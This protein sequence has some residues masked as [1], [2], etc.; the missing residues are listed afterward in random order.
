M[1]KFLLLLST[2]IVL[3][4]F[5]S[6][7]TIKQTSSVP[8]PT[9][10]TNLTPTQAATPTPEPTEE[11]TEVSSEEPVAT[12]TPEP[13]DE[14]YT[15]PEEIPIQEPTVA[16][17][18][19]PTQELSTPETKPTQKPEPIPK[20]TQKPSPTPK[21][22]NK[23]EPTPKPKVDLSPTPINEN[24]NSKYSKEA[25]NIINNIIT[26]DM[27]DVEKIKAVHD[28]I[29]VNTEY[30][31]DGLKKD[32]LPSSAYTEEGVLIKGKAVCQG[33]AE[34]F[35]LFME[36][37]KIESK[38][39]VGTDLISNI[40]HAWNMV[41][42]KDNWYHIDITWDDPVPDQ[43]EK[44]QYKYFLIRDIDIAKDHHWV[45]SDYPKCNSSDYLYYIYKDY[46]V[47]SIDNIEGKFMEQYD[48]GLR[49][50]TLLYPEEG[51]P[52]F[53]F[54][55]KYDYL[56]KKVDGGLKVD[57]SYYPPWQLGDYYV[58]IVMME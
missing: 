53:A 19:T 18:P 47:D 30:D 50:I 9:Q 10:M 52:D 24:V 1:R 56:W 57:Y 16:P 32:N 39:V 20:P 22:T 6:C 51:M 15:E 29:V 33:Y 13:T 31:I 2:Y 38:M 25:I 12:P 58:L 35:Q 3:A 41:R 40:G 11:P 54:M 21:P 4:S 43:G 36:L 28:Y 48:K 45:R 44:I 27:S 55:N 23:P 8:E 7:S 46:I 37:L 5:T 34:A 49:E 17:E 42:I 14:P 26:V